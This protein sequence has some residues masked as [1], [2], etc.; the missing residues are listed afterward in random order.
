V[1]LYGWNDWPAIDW[2]QRQSLRGKP[3]ALWLYGF[4]SSDAKP[5]PIKLDTLRPF[6]RQRQ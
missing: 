1:K 4:Y 5:H 6:D 2:E 3:F